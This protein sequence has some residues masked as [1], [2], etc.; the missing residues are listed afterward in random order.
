MQPTLQSESPVAP[1][2]TKVQV[3]TRR[4]TGR[5]RILSHLALTAICLI[6]GFPMIFA[7]IKSTQSVGQ[8]F[9][10][11]PVFIPGTHAFQNY[12]DAWTTGNLA[13]L[14]ANTLIVAVAISLGK[15]ALSL[16]AGMAF[17][18]FRFPLRGVLFILVLITLMMPTDILIVAHCSFSGERDRDV[19]VSPA[20]HEYASGASRRR[21][22]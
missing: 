16:M 2:I 19:S 14:M 13:R 1:I 9:S 6:I 17:V 5:P 18:Y 11:P 4:S 15:T 12:A 7:V 22:D 8:I 3:S 10:Y 20:L 21:T